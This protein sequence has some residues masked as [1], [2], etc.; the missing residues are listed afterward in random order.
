MK[1][2]LLVNFILTI[3][4]ITFAQVP[5]TFH[6]KPDYTEFQKLRLTGTFNG[7]NNAD[8]DLLMSDSDGDGEYEVTVNLTTGVDHNYKFVMD[9][10]WNFAYN[11]P[12]NPRINLDDNNNSILMAK[13][14]V[15]TYLLPRDVN[16]RGEKFIDN[17]PGGLPIRAIFA[18]T[19]G[20]PIDLNS[21][22]V[23][24]DGVNVMNPSQYYDAQKKEFLYYGRC[25][26][27][28]PAGKSGIKK[29][30]R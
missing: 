16:S 10:D 8:N 20:N 2:A 26:S 23:S 29:L 3:C 27:L 28:H 17:T 14:P 30:R 11:D 18:F 13:D 25:F 24:I 15:I 12:D 6:Y 9:A 5:V 21:L 7:W 19:S 22:T 4:S 1:K